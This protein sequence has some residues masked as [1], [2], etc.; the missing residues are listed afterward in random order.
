MEQESYERPVNVRVRSFNLLPLSL[1]ERR[2]L[3]SVTKKLMDMS[4]RVKSNQ[5]KDEREE[6]RKM[7]RAYKSFN[8]KKKKRKEKIEGD[9]KMMQA[10]DYKEDKSRCYVV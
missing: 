3:L 7:V 6:R 1:I 2:F 5:I 9:A 10:K 8:P 4:C